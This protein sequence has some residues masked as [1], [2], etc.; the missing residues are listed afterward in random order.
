V[1]GQFEPGE[2]EVVRIS[3]KALGALVSHNETLFIFPELPTP[4]TAGVFADA[5]LASDP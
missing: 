3:A 1:T 2:Q 5:S 4:S